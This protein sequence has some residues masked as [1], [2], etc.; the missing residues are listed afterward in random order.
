MMNMVD[1]YVKA[2]LKN[3]CV[4]PHTKE[5]CERFSCHHLDNLAEI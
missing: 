2:L 1:V 5:S 3:Q 4:D